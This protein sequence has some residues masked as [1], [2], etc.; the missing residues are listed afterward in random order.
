MRNAILLAFVACVVTLCGCATQPTPDQV[1][2]AVRIARLDG[3]AA[4]IVLKQ[5]IKAT[6]AAKVTAAITVVEHVINACAVDTCDSLDASLNT[7]TTGTTDNKFIPLVAAAV[8]TAEAAVPPN[9]GQNTYVAI[10]LSAVDGC[11]AGLK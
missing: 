6:E 3:Q 1:A 5:S 4:C 2:N 11:K 10:A 7:L 9:L 8:L